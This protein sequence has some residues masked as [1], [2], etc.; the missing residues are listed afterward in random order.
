MNFIINILDA[1]FMLSDVREDKDQM[2]LREP[3]LS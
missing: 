1:F 2:R 3:T